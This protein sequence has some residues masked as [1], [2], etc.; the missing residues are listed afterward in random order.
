MVHIDL[1]SV[2]ST[3]SLSTQAEHVLFFEY[4]PLYPGRD[5]LERLGKSWGGPQTKAI[6][7]KVFTAVANWK[8][9]FAAFGVA[10]SDMARFGEI[11]EYLLR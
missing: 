11:D 5:T 9:E 3:A 10:P 6:V 4:D 8:E 7:E 2:I 1:S